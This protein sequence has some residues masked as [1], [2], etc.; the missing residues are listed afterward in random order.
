MYL[1]SNISCVR[2]ME[3]L[4]EIGDLLGNPNIIFTETDNVRYYDFA[5]D[6]RKVLKLDITT[7]P[8]GKS[9]HISLFWNVDK[10]KAID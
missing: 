2:R 8:T 6:N 3:A 1:I 4:Q 7:V 10:D 9:N 5:Y